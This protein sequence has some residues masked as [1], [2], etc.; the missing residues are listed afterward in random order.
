LADIFGRVAENRRLFSGDEIQEGLLRKRQRLIELRHQNDW[1]GG[2]YDAYGIGRPAEL[3][4]NRRQIKDDLQSIKDVISGYLLHPTAPVEL[5]EMPALAA[6]SPELN[7]KVIDGDPMGGNGGEA[8]TYAD[9][10][11]AIRS[12]KRLTAVGL[13]TG[14]RV[15][16]IRLT[17]EREGDALSGAE[18]R[19]EEHGG[20]GGAEAGVLQLGPGESIRRIEWETGTQVDKLFLSGAGQRIGGGGNAGIMRPDLEVPDDRV[21]IGFSG[22]IGGRG[23]RQEVVA[24][25][26][27]FAVLGPL[28]WQPLV[29]G[30]D[31]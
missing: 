12:R 13:R 21:L 29:E 22:R 20:T 1:V 19:E 18:S 6:G 23:D 30:D 2:T 14:S 4:S 9:R 10:A 3:N 26:P 28:I 24:L 17:Y 11:T 8:F 16:Q 7:V 15:D 25:T 5:P 27:V 31:P